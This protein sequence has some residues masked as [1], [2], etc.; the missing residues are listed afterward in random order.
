[1]RYNGYV[2]TVFNA[3]NV[4]ND[5][6]VIV[7]IKLCRASDCLLNLAVTKYFTAHVMEIFSIV[8]IILVVF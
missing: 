6:N 1:M 8:G 7:Y 2:P 3:L 5:F 4:G